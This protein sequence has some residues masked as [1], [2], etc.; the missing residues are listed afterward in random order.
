MGDYCRQVPLQL[1]TEKR[2]SI[3][4]TS[5]ELFSLKG[6]RVAIM[7]EPDK[8]MKLYEGTMKMLT[9]GDPFTARDLYAP[10]VTFKPMFSLMVCCNYF[11][12]IFSNDEGT[13]RRIKVVEFE[14]LFKDKNEIDNKTGLPYI[15]DNESVWEKDSLLDEKMLRWK[16]AMLY[17]LVEI[18]FKTQGIV[19][20]CKSVTRRTKEYRD[21]QNRIQQFVDER[22]E[23]DD[24]YQV[25]KKALSTELK[26]WYDNYN[27]KNAKPKE[28]YEVLNEQGFEC[29]DEI[30][31]GVQIKNSG[32]DTQK[33]TEKKEQIFA[34][35]F[36][37]AYDITDDDEDFVITTDIEEW[38]KDKK[39]QMKSPK[40]IGKVLESALK[41]PEE[42]HIQKKVDVKSPDGKKKARRVWL[43]I[44]KRDVPNEVENITTQMN[45][46][47]IGGG[48]VESDEESDIEGI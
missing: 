28:L 46:V 34:N 3:G 31:F 25:T 26:N 16:E 7:A 14:T 39:L 12:N 36:K 33:P 4:S 32:G 24:N 18:V 27:L 5:S 15:I 10:S 48:Y 47:I 23:K 30:Y 20:D 8:E 29:V 13:W 41:I 37:K 19:K 43:G 22:L 21:E 11:F 2:P 6:A 1:I 17:R 38:A 44:K 9:G 45:N 42:K 35:E 40:E